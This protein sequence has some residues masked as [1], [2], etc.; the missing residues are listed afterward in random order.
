M[1]SSQQPRPQQ[2][3]D[4][5]LCFS[6]GPQGLGWETWRARGEAGDSISAQGP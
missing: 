5:S 2:L 1:P 4:H 6:L 3:S